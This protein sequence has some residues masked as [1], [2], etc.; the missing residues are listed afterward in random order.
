MQK[1]YLSNL[2][3]P[4]FSLCFTLLSGSFL[5]LSSSFLS[6]ANKSHDNMAEAA[7][8]R[9][10]KPLEDAQH[11]SKETLL[12]R[13]PLELKNLL[14]QVKAARDNA[15]IEEHIAAVEAEIAANNEKVAKMNNTLDVERCGRVV[16][17][18]RKLMV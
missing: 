1:P 9:F 10:L 16:G 8:R 2:S 4:F 5:F 6:F 3:Q 7:A 12:E 18:E 15:E 11:S 17:C 14:D 13:S